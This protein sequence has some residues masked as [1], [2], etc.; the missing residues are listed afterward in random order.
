MML[1][2]GFV[3]VC[4][5]ASSQSQTDVNEVVAAINDYRSDREKIII[6]D[7][8][9]LLSMPNVAANFADMDRNAD[10]VTELL[11]A[12]GFETKRLKAGGVHAWRC[13]WSQRSQ[14]AL[15]SQAR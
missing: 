9:D 8:V 11:V 14:S 2:I 7:F 4:A 10:Y 15:T 5:N 13:T 6:E 3:F 12:R 1:F